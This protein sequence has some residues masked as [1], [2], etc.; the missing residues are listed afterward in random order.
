MQNFSSRS[1]ITEIPSG[2]A[3]NDPDRVRDGAPRDRTD[4]RK[5][6]HNGNRSADRATD[7]RSLNPATL[8]SSYSQVKR[9]FV[10]HKEGV[11]K[12]R[13]RQLTEF[14]PAGAPAVDDYPDNNEDDD[15]DADDEEYSAR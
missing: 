4:C 12:R 1:L 13:Y 11:E 5:V 9:A 8:T 14:I 15:N 7:P 6:H 2:T 10:N 3:K